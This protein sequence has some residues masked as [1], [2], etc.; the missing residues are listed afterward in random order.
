MGARVT[1]APAATLHR[2]H[3]AVRLDAPRR[4]DL[5]PLPP[6][7]GSAPVGGRVRPFRS[8]RH[9]VLASLTAAQGGAHGPDAAD[10]ARLIFCAYRGAVREVGIADAARGPSVHAHAIAWATHSTIA[11]RLAIHAAQAGLDTDRGLALVHEGQRASGRA[12]RAWTAMYVA[13]GLLRG[14]GPGLD[15]QHDE[16][17]QVMRDGAQPREA[18]A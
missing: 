7:A 5:K 12:E 8:S 10:L 9:A 3:D 13:A 1:P 6:G 17:A 11:Q 16:L 15:A 14:R 4:R 2:S 18:P